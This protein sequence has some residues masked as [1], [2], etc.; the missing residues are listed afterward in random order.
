MKIFVTGATGFIGSHI[1]PLLQKDGHHVIGLSRSD[2]STDTLTKIGVEPYL[3]TIDDPESL[4]DAAQRADAIIHTAFD[5]DF[6]RFVENC[7]KD[8]NVILTLGKA[9][10]GTSKPLIITSGVGIGDPG[11]RN[12]ANE[13]TFNP[14][15]PNPRIASEVAG[16]FL[17]E[18]GIDVRVVRLPQVHDTQHHGL[19]STYIQIAA[20]QGFAA[21]VE[22]G[23]NCWSAC[24]VTDVA[25]IYR[26]VL[27]HGIKG[28]RYHAVGEEAI[29]A[30]DVAKA[31]SE[32]LNIPVC[33]I[34][35]AQMNEY[36]GWFSI[37]ADKDLSASSVWTRNNLNWQ[38]NSISLISDIY[39]S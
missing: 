14:N 31:V 25:E 20:T 6:T 23:Q 36:F 28:M 8:R 15:H 38:P 35:K 10:E 17:L 32:K 7:E 33:S 2:K 29:P 18:K 12:L 27:K 24:H 9:I 22:D 30:K 19:I 37:F 1:I 5:H 34:P 39:A 16:N 13:F 21:F 26:L 3:G 4:I 11:D